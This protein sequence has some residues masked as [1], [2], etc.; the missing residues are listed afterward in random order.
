MEAGR[1]EIAII[2][3]TWIGA[4][5]LDVAGESCRAQLHDTEKRVPDLYRM[6]TRGATTASPAADVTHAKELLQGVRPNNDVA[7][8]C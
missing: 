1:A 4:I 2:G 5:A 8:T 3:F 6:N 7:K